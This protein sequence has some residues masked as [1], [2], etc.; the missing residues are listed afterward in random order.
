MEKLVEYDLLKEN[1]LNEESLKKIGLFLD[2]DKTK[3]FFKVIS[4]HF[5][6]QVYDVACAFEKITANEIEKVKKTKRK[7][8]HELQILSLDRI[9]HYYYYFEDERKMKMF[10]ELRVKISEAISGVLEMDFGD[11]KQD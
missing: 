9:K 10:K 1:I 7:D 8:E 6:G 4:K 3:I 5:P 11:R 2:F